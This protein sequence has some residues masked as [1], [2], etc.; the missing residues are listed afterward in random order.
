MYQE[1]DTHTLALALD[2][3]RQEQQA[4]REAAQAIEAELFARI[5]D[6]GG[7]SLPDDD[8]K[9]ELKHSSP[10]Y[11]MN[12]LT[13]LLE[14]LPDDDKAKAYSPATTKVIDVPEKW[15]GTQLNAL[16]R[17]YGGEIA[18]R[19]EQAKIP[20]KAHLEVEPKPPKVALGS[21]SAQSELSGVGSAV[22]PDAGGE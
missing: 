11:D 20:G 10:T 4:L 8:F 12:A 9:I 2:A 21:P 22:R 16:A 19:I 15:S 13:P 6:S 14:I 7:T 1:F 18:H 3:N 17:R 5:M